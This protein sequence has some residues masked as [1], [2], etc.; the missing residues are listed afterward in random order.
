MEELCGVGEGEGE[1]GG[2]RRSPFRCRPISST[3]FGTADAAAVVPAASYK[4]FYRPYPSSASPSSSH[5]Q[6]Q[7]PPPE[8]SQGD[9]AEIMSHPKYSDLLAAFVDCQKVTPA[10]SILQI[11]CS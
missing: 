7:A 4:Y 1:G 6:L 9:A 2:S 11:I 8:P 5:L 3:D 10:H